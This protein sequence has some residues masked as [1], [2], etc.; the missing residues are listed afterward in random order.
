MMSFFLKSGFNVIQTAMKR[1]LIDATR[2]VST[3][4]IIFGGY[5]IYNKTAPLFTRHRFFKNDSNTIDIKEICEY[6][7]KSSFSGS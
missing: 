1:S 7:N 4:G 2:S 6:N 3:T 5:Y